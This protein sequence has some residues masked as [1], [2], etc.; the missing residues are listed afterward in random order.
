LRLSITLHK[1]FRSIVELD[2]HNTHKKY[3]FIHVKY[4]WLKISRC[5]WK[6]SDV[7]F[8]AIGQCFMHFKKKVLSFSPIFHPLQLWFG[9]NIFPIV[10]SFYMDFGDVKKLTI[11]D[12]NAHFYWHVTYQQWSIKWSIEFLSH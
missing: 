6:L 3:Y 1:S 7:S 4:L 5:K 8:H 2:K 12:E 11:V 9:K 10:Q